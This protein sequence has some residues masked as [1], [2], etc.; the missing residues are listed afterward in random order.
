MKHYIN[1]NMV[2]RITLNM[3][4]YITSTIKKQAMN[5]KSSHCPARCISKPNN[6][7][8]IGL[9]SVIYA[10]YSIDDSQQYNR[11]YKGRIL[12]VKNHGKLTLH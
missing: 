11:N 10:I 2:L 9:P 5:H 3:L 8:K 12:I 7:F 6:V 4:K 1:L